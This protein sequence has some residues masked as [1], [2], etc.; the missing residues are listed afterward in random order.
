M[1]LLKLIR[2]IFSLVRIIFLKLIYLKELKIG[3]YLGLYFLS[4]SVINIR[5]GKVIFKGKPKIRENT[6][7]N[8][9]DGY[10]E[11]GENTFINSKCSINSHI[12]IKIG[13]DCLFGENVQIYDHDHI[14]Y[15]SDKLTEKKKFKKKS[16]SIGNNVW[17]GSNVLI[18]KGVTIGDNC[19]IGA[20][21]IVTKDIPKNTLYYSKQNYNI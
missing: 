8:V 19:V 15:L 4:G 3:N 12:S 10:V 20:G 14:F 17:L 7:I 13:K 21:T 2:G 16:I 1:F 18:L 5:N 6:K 9:I 11:I